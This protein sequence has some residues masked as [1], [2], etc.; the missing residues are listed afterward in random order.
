MGTVAVP[1]LIGM[2]PVPGAAA[3]RPWTFFVGRVAG[4]LKSVTPATPPLLMANRTRIRDA[5]C[6]VYAELEPV[7]A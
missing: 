1:V 6:N 5:G 3:S 7:Y 4:E 2:L